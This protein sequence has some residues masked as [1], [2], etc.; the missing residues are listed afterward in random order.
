M[1]S[2][3]PLALVRSGALT[4]CLRTIAVLF[5]QGLQH[6]RPVNRRL[7]G[8]DGSRAVSRLCRNRRNHVQGAG[9]LPSPF[10]FHAAELT[11]RGIL[12]RSHS[13]RSSPSL[14]RWFNIRQQRPH[15]LSPPSR[16]SLTRTRSPTLSSCRRKRSAAGSCTPRSWRVSS[17]ARWRWQ[18]VAR[19]PG[20][21]FS[22]R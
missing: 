21:G 18:V 9:A 13:A 6:R 7:S 8:A 10:P 15:N 1:R 16:S 22:S 14:R 17:E 20:E 11:F 5:L 4:P 2:K 3:S 19:L 12:D